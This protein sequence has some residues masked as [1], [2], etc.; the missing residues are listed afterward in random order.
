[1]LPGPLHPEVSGT[2]LDTIFPK[3][4]IQSQ[5]ERP[6]GRKARLVVQGEGLHRNLES[7]FVRRVVQYVQARALREHGARDGALHELDDE[8]GSRQNLCTLLC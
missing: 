8:V 6:D 2:L 7:A 4:C 3:R 5:R 1:M